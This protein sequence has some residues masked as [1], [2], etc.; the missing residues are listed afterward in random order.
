[1]DVIKIEEATDFLLL[2]RGEMVALS[3]KLDHPALHFAP[4]APCSLV[5]VAPE[6]HELAGRKSVSVQMLTEHAL[7]GFDPNEPYG[8]NIAQPFLDAGIP[9]ELSIQV[10]YAH[11]VLS[12]VQRKLGV[13][14]IDAFSVAGGMPAGVVKLPLDPPSRFMT[15][16]ATNIDAPPSNYAESLI[17]FLRSEAKAA[18]GMKD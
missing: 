4:L 11:S 13:A 9:F 3:Y 12:L 16:V 15:Y 1:M 2:K 7:I 14:V 8:R 17:E 10:R 18:A 6:G 5:A